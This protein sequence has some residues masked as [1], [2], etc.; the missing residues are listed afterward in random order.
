MGFANMKVPDA[1]ETTFFVL[2]ERI[3]SLVELYCSPVEAHRQ[4]RT[5]FLVF[6]VIGFFPTES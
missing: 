3:A 5:D 6:A 2:W 4:Y 1:C